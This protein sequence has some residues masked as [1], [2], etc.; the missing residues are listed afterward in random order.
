LADRA[1]IFSELADLLEED[2]ATAS[3]AD[4]DLADADLADAD[5][6]DADLADAD[7][8]DADLANADL[9]DA[10]LFIE[11]LTEG[12]LFTDAGLLD[13]DLL[14]LFFP[15]YIR[16]AFIAPTPPT[17]PASTGRIIAHTII[18]NKCK[19]FFF[20]SGIL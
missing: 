19:Y 9:D 20:N 18:C 6:A 5:L 2:L 10:D 8:A 4:A 14:T 11:G 12:V 16:L 15:V 17:I 3:L 1:G 7:L 13:I